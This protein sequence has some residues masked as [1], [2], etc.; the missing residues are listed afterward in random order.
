MD[1]LPGVRASYTAPLSQKREN[2]PFFDWLS[3]YQDHDFDLPV[4][5][6]EILVRSSLDT[7]AIV[8]ETVTNYVHKGSFD[9]A[10]LVRCNGSRVSVSGNPSKF[11]RPDNLQGIS[12]LADCLAI[13]N[14]ILEELELPPFYTTGN[15]YQFAD[16]GASGKR[17][18]ITR[19]DITKNYMVGE[20]NVIPFISWLATQK[21]QRDAG[22]VYA[23]GKTVDWNRGSRRVYIKYYD[24]SHDY[25]K[26]KKSTKYTD[27][28]HDYCKQVGLVRHEISLKSLQLKNLG[29]DNIQEWTQQTM[30]N[31]SEKYAFHSRVTGTRNSMHDIAADLIVLGYCPNLSNRCQMAALTWMSGVEFIPNETISKSAFYRLRKPLLEL[32]IDISLPCNVSTLPITIKEIEITDA[33][34]PDWYEIA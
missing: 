15:L 6:N 23:N 26:T 11:N 22:F 32:G 10:L 12:S 34:Y 30:K 19:V 21:H 27:Q 33:I 14:R 17:A 25:R 13:Y 1:D 9:S 2:A 20:G 3:V 4:L 18:V 8:S 28:L 29:L 24:K 16:G 7:G 31:I 5:G